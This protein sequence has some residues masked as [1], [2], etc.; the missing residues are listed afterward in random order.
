MA[1]WKKVALSIILNIGLITLG[2][3]AAFGQ[4]ASTPAQEK[5]SK[6]QSRQLL[7]SISIC[8]KLRA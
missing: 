8:Q 4:Q 1:S 5:Y 7:A 2:S 6:A 3:M